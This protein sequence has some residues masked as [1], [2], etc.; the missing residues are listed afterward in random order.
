[1]AGAPLGNDNATKGKEFNL[2]LRRA[3]ARKAN[4]PDY[5]KGLDLVADELVKA[6][7]AG[8]QWAVKEV[9]DREDGKSVQAITVPDGVSHYV[10]RVELVPLVGKG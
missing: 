1:M 10:T 8:E 2:A 7:C 5:R 3:L 9:A 6:A 4:E